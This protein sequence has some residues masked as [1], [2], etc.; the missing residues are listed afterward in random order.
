MGLFHFLMARAQQNPVEQRTDSLLKL[1][2]QASS[3]SIR[4]GRLLEI[5][6]LWSDWDTVRAFSYL[7][8]ANKLYPKPSIFQKGQLLFNEAGIIFEHDIS[9]AK[10]LYK[11][12]DSH[13]NQLKSPRAFLYRGKLW[14][15]YGALLQRQDSVAKFLEIT[16]EK[17]LPYVRQSG[18]Q[19][20]ISH[21]IINIG[22][23]F[24]NM[25]DYA[26]ARGYFEE[27]MDILSRL[28]EANEERITAF[29]SAAKNEMFLRE[30]PD[31]RRFLDSA[32]A[33][34]M[35]IP[36]S[37][38]IPEYYGA[39]GRYY[40][41]IKEGE[42]AIQF[43]EKGIETAR[44]LNDTHSMGSL[45]FQL[46]ALYRDRGDYEAAKKVLS[47]YQ[48]YGGVSNQDRLLVL[49][50]WAYLGYQT[51]DYR[52][53]YDSL[54]V[55]SNLQDSLH[56]QDLNLKLMDLEKKYQ[57]VEKEN[58]LLKLRETS[59]RQEHIITRNRRWVY[60]LSGVLATMCMAAY[61]IWRMNIQ[62]KKQQQYLHQ[63]ELDRIKQ[64]HKISMLSAMID[65]QENERAR[66]ARDLH[67]GLGGLLSGVKIE[68]SGGL[69]SS[70]PEKPGIIINNTLGRIDQA[71]DELRRIARNM[72]PEMLLRYGLDEALKE[73]CLSL[74]RTGVNIT[75]QIF[76]YQ[77]T[78]TESKQVVVYRIAQELVNNAI[79]YAQSN[80]IL[81]ELRQQDKGLSLT[82]EDN[83]R[84]FDLE[85]ARQRNGSGLANVEARAAFLNG[86]LQ[87]D[88]APDTG[89]S[90]VL[91]CPV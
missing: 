16:I 17:S 29:V 50:E 85:E 39:E 87:I 73:Y 20:H 26:R 2:R 90:V 21:N 69:D 53:A 31:A 71:M 6:Y 14:A 46:Y 48:S 79:K 27:A 42:R 11:E 24:M 22:L 32:K 10:Q 4:F 30:F 88:S 76:N 61:F 81:V 82:V 75:C 13:F 33:E 70:P 77:N 66:I 19:A 78:L 36:H 89:T 67:D 40:R 74:K 51:G 64:E 15:N 45:D 35:R 28:P 62:K 37:T 91:D 7:K 65:G 1:V 55:F 80:H 47:T 43:Y 60:G 52:T 8:D 86:R 83:G 18:D 57:T 38:F 12:A 41:Q 59:L 54:R 56:R 63:M 44:K 5:S 34:A 84:G 49:N 23:V 68:L 3:D 25:G 9:K 72:M 58:E